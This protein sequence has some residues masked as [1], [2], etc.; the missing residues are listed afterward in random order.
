MTT[1]R[2]HSTQDGNC[3][4]SEQVFSNALAVAAQQASDAV[5][6]FALT[7]LAF[8]ARRGTLAEGV[9]VLRYHMLI[10]SEWAKTRRFLET[11]V[12]TM[13]QRIRDE[14]LDIPLS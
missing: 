6:R 5:Q 12:R 10:H 4:M 3:P 11:E 9:N 13:R 1:T 2:T 7:M 8:E 14:G